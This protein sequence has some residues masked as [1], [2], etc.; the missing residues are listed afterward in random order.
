M[1]RMFTVNGAWLACR[2]SKVG[3]IEPGKVADLAVLSHDIYTCS[4]E[5]IKDIQVNMTMVDG[6]VVFS[7]ES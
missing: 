3:S 6:Q 5:S 7:R 1:L 2:E 4:E